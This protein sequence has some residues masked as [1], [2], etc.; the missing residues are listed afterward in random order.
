MFTRNYIR[1]ESGVGIYKAV[2]MHDHNMSLQVPGP[3]SCVL[4][5][6]FDLIL[7][8]TPWGGWIML[9]IKYWVSEKFG[10]RAQ[11]QTAVRDGKE[12]LLA[13]AWEGGEWPLWAHTKTLL[14]H[15]D[16]FSRGKDTT[17]ASAHSG[18][19]HISIFPEICPVVFLSHL[20]GKNKSYDEL[21]EVTSQDTEPLNTEI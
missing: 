9:E 6:L 11:G 19:G 1:L 21:V 15:K 20:R 17:R 13:L 4:H 8:T 18:E 5:E 12:P 7:T 14:H 2:A 3:A 10:F 16:I